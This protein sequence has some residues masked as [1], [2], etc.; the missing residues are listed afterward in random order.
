MRLAC[1]EC[2]EPAR[3]LETPLPAVGCYLT[4]DAWRLTHAHTDGSGLCPTMTP[5]GYQPCAPIPAEWLDATFVG[6]DEAYM[7]EDWWTLATDHEPL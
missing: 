2:H 6:E 3:K 5:R 1:S 4:V 7:G